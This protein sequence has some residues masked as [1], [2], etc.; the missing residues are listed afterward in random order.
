M[1]TSA[2]LGLLGCLYF[3]QGLPYGFFTKTV[4]F[5]MS[6][7]D[8]TLGAIGLTSLLYLP[9]ALKFLWAPLVDRHGATRRTWLIPLQIAAVAAL[10]CVSFLDPTGP[11]TPIL[12]G[13]VLINLVSATQDIPTD[14]T[15]VDL[16]TPDE[17]GLGN[18]VQVGAYRIGM[19]VGG[20]FVLMTIDFVG[21]TG[22]M[23]NMALMVALVTLPILAWRAPA[24]TSIEAPRIA[25]ALMGYVRR[26]GVAAWLG[27]L[28]LYKGFD[29]MAGPVPVALME[30]LGYT[31]VDLG[32][33]FGIGGSTA[34]LVGA[35][36]G[37]F[38]VRRFGR[39][40]AL[41]A[42]GVLQAIAVAL[43]AL[44]A[45]GI[46]GYGTMA[47][48]V[49]ADSLFGTLATVALF[50]MM[51]D[52]SRPESGATDYTVQASVV[53]I[54]AG[55]SGSLGGFVAD[56]LGLFPF[57]LTIAAATLL[58]L[59]ACAALIRRNGVPSC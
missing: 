25:A 51:M 26:P 16:L 45:A 23:L 13:L 3:S 7:R 54:A 50:T 52:A 31:K 37:G 36:L 30:R 38:A 10:V 12:I 56:A 39:V 35:I 29:A 43:Y 28:V 55:V 59:A 4:P 11:L 22:S 32:L 53:V 6:E 34:A 1:R 17:R 49:C 20:G 2:K 18:G 14:A 44:P 15:A 19:V 9:W 27:V 47:F 57:F 58:G 46:A 5:V 33:I 40:P 21:W 8:L 41:L 42:F 24:R 48:V